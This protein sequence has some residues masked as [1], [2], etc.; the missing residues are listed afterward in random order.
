MIDVQLESVSPNDNG[1]QVAGK[2]CQVYAIQRWTNSSGLLPST[3]ARLIKRVTPTDK[4]PIQ[5]LGNAR[6]VLRLDSTML[7]I[8]DSTDVGPIKRDVCQT[9]FPSCSLPP[10]THAATTASGH[11]S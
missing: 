10:P 2:Y 6:I 9:K 4:E 11:K 8:G 7:V 1:F 3:S 5:Q